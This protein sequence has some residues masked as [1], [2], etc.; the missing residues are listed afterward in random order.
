MSVFMV[1]IDF[2]KASID[3]RSKFSFTKKAASEAME[4]LKESETVEGAIILSTCNRMEVWASIEENG[5]CDTLF[6]FLCR[7]KEVNPEEYRDYFIFRQGREAAEHLFYLASGLKSQILAEDQ[8][9][10]QVSD[11]LIL[12]RDNYCTDSVLEVLFRKAITA[13]KKVKTKVVFSKANTSVIHQAVQKLKSEGI[14]LEGKKA[15]VIGNGAMGKLTALTLMEEGCD[16]TVTVRQYRSGVVEIPKGSDRI[17]YG[18]RYDLLPQCDLVVS[19]TASPNF[20]ITKEDFEKARTE[21]NRL[22]IDLAVPRDIEPTIAELEDIKLY[23]I[24]SFRI[25]GTTAS[26]QK[27]L[28]KAG[29]IIDEEMDNFYNWFEGRD[30][31]PKIHELKRDAV[32]D[33]NLRI[34]KEFNHSPLED[35]EKERLLDV[36][37][38]AAGKVIIKMLFGLRDAVDDNVF[39]E[40]LAGLQG[41][42][43]ED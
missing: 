23:D 32:E 13:A 18:D 34:V 33:F 7:E 10:T 38:T 2:N 24:D 28:D 17:N 6:D 22:L 1:G 14:S 8:I 11:A 16:V 43:D 5:S 35:E 37:N 41:V 42:Y 4:S 30:V 3:V 31:F 9:V 27:S 25:T 40:C 19:A 26:L 20:T 36:A 21:K 29:Q 15:M 39:S 12:S